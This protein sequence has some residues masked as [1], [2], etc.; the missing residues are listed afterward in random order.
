[1]IRFVY[2]FLQKYLL[3]SS[4]FL[5]IFSFSAMAAL[6]PEFELLYS[7]GKTDGQPS[8]EIVHDNLG[9]HYGVI[10]KG[11]A[12]GYG[13]LYKI[14]ASGNYSVL[15]SFDGVNGS[16]T[17]GKLTLGSANKFYGITSNSSAD[18]TLS[19]AVI[20]QLDISGD[21]P[22]FSVL[23]KPD[24]DEYFSDLIVSRDGML[25]GSNHSGK[26]FQINPNTAPPELTVLY[27]ISGF[28]SSSPTSL[29]EG[30]DGKIYGVVRASSNSFAIF[31]LDKSTFSPI[32]KV[33]YSFPGAT[34]I[35]PRIMQTKDGQF[36]GVIN[37]R[38]TGDGTRSELFK[39]D[40]SASVATY[41]LIYG[42]DS[43]ARF[44][45][46]LVAVR[47]TKLYGIFAR[48]V[49]QLDVSGQV[50]KFTLLN[51]IALP[52]YPEEGLS[53]DGLGNL[54][55]SV[56]YTALT[57]NGLLFK[58]DVA[59]SSPVYSVLHTFKNTHGKLPEAALVE[60][61]DGML[62]GT[63]SRGGEGGYGTVFKFDV[64][65]KALRYH[66]LLAFNLKNGGS[67]ETN[68]LFGADGK[69]YGTTAFGVGENGG[70]TLFQLDISK[71]S[72]VHKILHQFDLI[73]GYHPSADF[74]R[75]SDGKFYGTTAFGN[76]TA[77]S[78]GT[79][80]QYDPSGAMPNYKLLHGFSGI[81]GANPMGLMQSRDGKFY[82][83]TYHSANAGILYQFDALAVTPSFQ[84]LYEFLNPGG[85][86]LPTSMGEPISGLMQASN[87]KF[88]GTTTRGGR[89]GRGIVFSLD[90][91]VVNPEPEIVHEFDYN[92]G[93]DPRGGL[94]QANDGKLYGATTG[95]GSTNQGVVY[96]LDISGVLPVFKVIHVFNGRDGANPVRD[97]IQASDGNLYGVTKAG[98]TF[99]TG[100]DDGGI[101]YRIKLDN[102]PV[103]TAPT[104]GN[105]S[106][107]FKMR[108][109]NKPVSIAAPGVLKN[110]KDG[111]GDKLTV[112]GAT[113]RKPR[114]IVL[115]KGAGKVSLY[116]NGRLVYERGK[117][118]F[119]GSQSFT[120][121]V[122]DGKAISN[123]A[124]VTLTIRYR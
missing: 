91:S 45:G 116:P 118:C 77:T 86:A 74:I 2:G 117:K 57:G 11:G 94:I 72:P 82:G 49:F 85:S 78:G 18:N 42:S 32:Y 64:S 30:I 108:K 20:Y 69:L 37:Y 84:L 63:T 3:L 22:V 29:L 62:Y 26:F 92:N 68:L 4:L 65:Q 56:S 122:T 105:D 47:N 17:F 60:G 40:L 119:F 98:G 51:N 103:N 90:T 33:L 121:R 113:A 70:G 27:N 120:Y 54:Y 66:D 16:P 34:G 93:Q 88:Y 87:G 76:L 109:S 50:P 89:F 8:S 28:T 100:F 38:N 61:R 15:Y 95:G 75:G 23:Y 1:M 36:Y 55:G 81:D 13:A 96:Q 123:P 73:N 9:N 110:D 52:G 71:A 102:T 79:I 99:S 111:E 12:N 7:L 67:P 25:L 41:N 124:R 106:Y 104:A 107:V 59:G 44:E 10:S 46:G 48:S 97:L 112:V 58:V 101:I 5:G 19:N 21:S 43:G 31:S 14:D 24:V 39:V 83:T 35:P 6:P 114:V 115:V 80:F 53:Y